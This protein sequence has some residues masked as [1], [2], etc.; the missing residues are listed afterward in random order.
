ML[1]VMGQAR[2]RSIR[3]SVTETVPV[4]LR[5]WTVDDKSGHPM[6]EAIGRYQIVDLI[7][8]GGFGR[9]FKGFD[10]E[11]E[12]SVAVKVFS[13]SPGLS[14]PMVLR[15]PCWRPAV[16]QSSIIVESSRSTTWE[17]WM[18]A[19]SILCRS[20]SKGRRSQSG[21]GADPMPDSGG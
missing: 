21:C 17:K 4:I 14:E 1:Y 18:T 15:T 19:R 8:E 5:R 6:H 20:L 9:V 12:R 2:C 10:R 3:R 16:S 13:G 7:G 11:L